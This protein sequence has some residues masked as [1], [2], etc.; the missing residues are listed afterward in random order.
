MQSQGPL[1]TDR[2]RFSGIDWLNPALALGLLMVGLISAETFPL[3][4]GAALGTFVWF[5]RH[6]RYDIY[7]DALVVSYGKPRQKV[8]PLDQVSEVR[9]VQ[10]GFRGDSLFVRNTSGHGM[11]IRPSD[12]EQFAQRLQEA[13]RRLTE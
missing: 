11:I 10:F 6:F 5:T 3:V 1:H 13:L 12:P 2:P 7:P 8:V 9:T 4:S